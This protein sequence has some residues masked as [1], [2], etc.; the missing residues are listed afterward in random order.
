MNLSELLVAIAAGLAGTTV[1]THM[2]LGG[3]RAR[4]HR[5]FAVLDSYDRWLRT[6]MLEDGSL[7]IGGTRG[8]V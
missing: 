5:E 2:M 6:V 8:L 1:M 3:K 7:S 4:L